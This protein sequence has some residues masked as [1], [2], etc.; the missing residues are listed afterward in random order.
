MKEFICMAETPTDTQ[1]KIRQW[2]STG[3][4]IDIL[5]QSSTT[6]GLGNTTVVTSLIRT[7]IKLLD[8]WTSTQA[9]SIGSLPHSL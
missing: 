2:L 1:K 3:Y 7:N 9:T 5:A 6:D 4:S 8:E